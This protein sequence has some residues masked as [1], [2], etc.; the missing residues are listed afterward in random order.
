M[1][2]NFLPIISF[3]FFIPFVISAQPVDDID[4]IADK[5]V[6]HFLIETNDIENNTAVGGG[7]GGGLET[8]ADIFS[9][10]LMSS[11][12]EMNRTINDVFGQNFSDI[13]SP[14]HLI[15]N[16]QEMVSNLNKQLAL[17]QDNI[18]V[19]MLYN[20]SRHSVQ[21]GSAI[22]TDSVARPATF[23]LGQNLRLLGNGLSSLGQSLKHSGY[24]ISNLE[25]A[26]QHVSQAL[27]E[28][29][30]NLVNTSLTMNSNSSELMENL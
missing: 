4:L 26:I 1:S 5:N 12:N 14:G 29:G 16:S 15:N 8:F 2:L 24:H 10:S 13:L 25:P 7:G 23:F 22:L 19:N 17:L 11:I 9:S 18:V 20:A 28:Y 3:C 27:S 21:T 30:L 6:T